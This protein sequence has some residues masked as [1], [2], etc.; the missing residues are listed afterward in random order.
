M[1]GYVN[2]FDVF[3]HNLRD[4]K[5]VGASSQPSEPPSLERNVF[6]AASRNQIGRLKPFY[7][8]HRQ[9]I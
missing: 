1:S 7:P 2:A 8:A 9:L 6:L 4:R 3:D 5:P